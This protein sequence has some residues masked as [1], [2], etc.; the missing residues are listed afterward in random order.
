M[1]R[2]KSS[3][4]SNYL[5]FASRTVLLGDFTIGEDFLSIDEVRREMCDDISVR[6]EGLVM[7]YLPTFKKSSTF[8]SK[9]VNYLIEIA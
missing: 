3:R 1:N 6:G 8:F 7:L 4:S 5:R 2:A 9:T